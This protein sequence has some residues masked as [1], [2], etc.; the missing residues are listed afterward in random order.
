MQ[1]AI[2]RARER[3]CSVIQLTTDLR[4]TDAHRFYVGLGFEASHA[5]MKHTL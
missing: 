5:G 2:D 3:G 4:R 1:K